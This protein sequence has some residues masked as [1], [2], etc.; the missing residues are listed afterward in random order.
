MDIKESRKLIEELKERNHNLEKENITLEMEVKASRKIIHKL[1]RDNELLGE[2]EEAII[3]KDDLI[4][5]FEKGKT[6][7]DKII[8]NLQNEKEGLKQEL[9]ATEKAN[10]VKRIGL[11]EL[12]DKKDDEIRDLLQEVNVIQEMNEKKEATLL[13][14]EEENCQVKEKLR[15]LEEKKEV[16]EKY[17]QTEDFHFEEMESHCEMGI[18]EPKSHN[19]S[20]EFDPL[21]IEHIP[22]VAHDKQKKVLEL[23]LKEMEM[24]RKINRQQLQFS[25][26][27]FKLKEREHFEKGICR[28][29]KFCRIFHHKY[30]W[31]KSESTELFLKFDFLTGKLPCEQCGEKFRNNVDLEKHNEAKHQRSGG[32]NGEILYVDLQGGD[33]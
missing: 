16:L 12:K 14:L 8:K 4:E 25:S 30:N 29:R 9:E 13:R 3:D 5:K 19:V 23:K 28:C 20:L 24:V 2:Y 27:L 18:V 21:T 26:D 11:D 7:T 10:E 6:I 22:D 1:K 15:E 31:R 17:V 33:C 32:E